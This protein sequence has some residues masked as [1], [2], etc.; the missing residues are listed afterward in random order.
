MNTSPNSFIY[1]T[2]AFLFIVCGARG[3]EPVTQNGKFATVKGLKLYY[4]ESG[5]GTPL[6]L[7]HNFFATTSHW[8]PFIPQFSKY[9]KVIAIDLPGHGRSD[10]MDSTDVYLNKKAAEYVIGLLDYL[11]IDSV[12]VI[13][14]STGGF[15][16]LYM[17]KMR[18]ELIKK[19]IV[20]G[21]QVYYSVQNRQFITARGPAAGIAE[22]LGASIKK[23]GKE[24]GTLLEKQF[25]RFRDLYGDPS[26]TS[27]ILATVTAKTLIIHGDNDE[28]APMSNAL[29][30]YN[31]LP[32]ANLWIVPNGGHLPHLNS[33]NH[34]DFTRRALEFLGNEWKK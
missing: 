25:W 33:S 1:F 3:Q 28:I 6:L 31:S 17:A 32:R 8:Q 19:M 13:G 7:L 11:K 21:G 34:A 23:H 16:A 10:Y 27:D 20:I 29:E 12:Y 22:R 5:K 18:P 4:E 24:K 2:I 30:M 15:I 14:A 9:Y 26:F